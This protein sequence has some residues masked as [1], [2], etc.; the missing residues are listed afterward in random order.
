M[1]PSNRYL[2]HT[3]H[4]PR[5]PIQSTGVGNVTD[6]VTPDYGVGQCLVVTIDAM[7][8]PGSHGSDSLLDRA[9]AAMYLKTSERHIRQ[10]W[11]TRQLAAVRVGRLIRFRRSDLDAFITAHRVEAVRR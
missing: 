11:A 10:L 3:G 5:T 8:T 1:A 9:E 4:R 7:K 6:S 2:S